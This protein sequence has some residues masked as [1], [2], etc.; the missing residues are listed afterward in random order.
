MSTTVADLI[1]RTRAA[2][3]VLASTAEPV[4]DELQYLADLETVWGARLRAVA[5]ARGA[6][7]APDGAEAAIGALEAEAAAISDP[8]RAIDWM[9][10][11]PQVAL[12]AIGEAA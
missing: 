7:V 5:D 11:L 3:D 10:T 12:A 8:H 4:A 9:S 1:A 6:E 2:F